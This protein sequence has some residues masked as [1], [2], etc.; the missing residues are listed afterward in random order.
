V[1]AAAVL[2]PAD[3]IEVPLGKLA[4]GLGK[5]TISAPKMSIAV[6]VGGGSSWFKTPTATSCVHRSQSAA[7]PHEDDSYSVLG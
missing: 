3:N 1:A 4:R 2:G 5:G 6:G 7:D